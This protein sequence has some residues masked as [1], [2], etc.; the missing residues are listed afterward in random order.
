MI[1]AEFEQDG[2]RYGIEIHS[3]PKQAC[4]CGVSQWCV[5]NPVR[6]KLTE[7]LKPPGGEDLIYADVEI[8]CG[9]CGERSTRKV[10]T[11]YVK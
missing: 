5:D 10:L 2:R 1:G 6:A 8:S 9:G 7:T 3:E 11:T 4:H